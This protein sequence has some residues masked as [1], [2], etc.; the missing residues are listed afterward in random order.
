ME[1]HAVEVGDQPRPLLQFDEADGQRVLEGRH[2]RVVHDDVRV[3]RAAAARLHRVPLQRAAHGAGRQRRVAQRAARG[4]VL[5][6]QLVRAGTLEPE[7]VVLREGRARA[8]RARRLLHRRQVLEDAEAHGGHRLAGVVERLHLVV[9]HRPHRHVGVGDG[10]VVEAG[11]DEAP[12][13]QSGALR[14]R[15]R[16]ND[17]AHQQ[18]VADH[19]G[20]VVVLLA[21][22]GDD[23][24]QALVIEQGHHLLVR[25]APLRGA[26]GPGLLGQQRGA[27]AAHDPGLQ[28]GGRG[29]E[30]VVSRGARRLVGHV[31]RVVIAHRL[32][33][34]P[35]HRD[36]HRV[37]RQVRR[38]GR[39]PDQRGQLGAVVR[40]RRQL[41]EPLRRRRRSG[42][43]AAVT[44]PPGSS[45]APPWPRS[46]AAPRSPRPRTC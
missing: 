21:V 35:D 29:D 9:R 4:A 23:R 41:L 12:R 17:G 8:R 25:P 2:L 39:L 44:A 28:H 32:D 46:R 37:G 1:L 45:P 5:N 15:D 43:A 27:Q 18:P 26:L 16:L 30:L 13:A 36:V 31:H 14:I 19:Q 34:V 38:T 20:A 10:D 42:A 33:P 6:Q 40:E 24:G 11:G 22:G 3:H 7:R